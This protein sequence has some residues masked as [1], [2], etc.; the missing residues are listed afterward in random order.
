MCSF[1]NLEY[2]NLHFV[3]NYIGQILIFLL[4]PIFF[5]YIVVYL[6]SIIFQYK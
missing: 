5:R 1:E 4:T 6:Q 2:G 3:H